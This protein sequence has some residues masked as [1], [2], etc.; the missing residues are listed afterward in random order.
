MAT[1]RQMVSALSD[2]QLDAL[3]QEFKNQQTA[4][5]VKESE[6]ARRGGFL[7]TAGRALR[8]GVTAGGKRIVSDVREMAGMSPLEKPVDTK[9]MYRELALFKFKKQIEDENKEWKPQTQEEALEFEK[10][11]GLFKKPVGAIK[12]IGNSLVKYDS[13]TDVAS[14]IY[15]APNTSEIIKATS[16]AI[17]E[18]NKSTGTLKKIINE[19]GDIMESPFDLSEEKFMGEFSSE[20]EQLIADNMKAYNKSREEVIKALQNKGLL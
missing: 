12:V 7:P 13:Q 19:F 8:A 15:T 3:T 4:E 9:E 20:Q 14:P 5:S 6:G 17:F 1:L 10:A 18:R 2:E 11:K 16:G